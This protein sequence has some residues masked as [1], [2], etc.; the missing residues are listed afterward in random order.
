MYIHYI[1]VTND[2]N[3]FTLSTLCTLA[4]ENANHKRQCNIHYICMTNDHNEF[5]LSTLC[6][7]ACE[8]ANHKR[9]CKLCRS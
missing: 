4:C 9:Q 6:T 1:Y 2:H 8:N 7:L 3:E 5:T